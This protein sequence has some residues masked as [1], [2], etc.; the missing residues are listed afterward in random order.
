MFTAK[1]RRVYGGRSWGLDFSYKIPPNYLGLQPGFPDEGGGKVAVPKNFSPGQ[2]L[3]EKSSVS[4]GTRPVLF[5]FSH[6]LFRK[7]EYYFRVILVPAPERKTGLEVYCPSYNGL[8]GN[9]Q[10]VRLPLDQVAS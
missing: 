5:Y 10:G 4:H 6:L 8:L 2:P 7:R 9:L 3:A 1:N